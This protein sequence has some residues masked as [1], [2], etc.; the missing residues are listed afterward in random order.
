[1][2]TTE[3]VGSRYAAYSTRTIRLIGL[4][5]V[6]SG[7]TGLIYEVLWARM[8]GL[9]FGATT[10]AVSTVLAAFMGG[11]SLGS[12]LAGRFPVVKRPLR[13][14]GLLE[15]G[16]AAYA[17]LVPSLFHHVDDLYAYIWQHL[18]P[19]YF[20]FSIWRFALSCAIL[21]VPTTL[22]GATLP[23]LTAAVLRSSNYTANSVTRLYAYNLTGA[24]FGTLVAGFFLLPGIGL[25]STIY[26]SALINLA[27]GVVAIVLDRSPERVADWPGEAANANEGLSQQIESK[28]FWLFCAFISGFVTISIQVAWTRLLSMIIGSSTYAFSLVVAL[29][30]IGLSLGAYVVGNRNRSEKLRQ[31]VFRVEVATAVSL[32]LSL[33][34]VGALPDLLVRFGLLLRLNSW[35]GLLALQVVAASLLILLP[36]FLM[37]T[38]M[39]LV[40]VWAGKHQDSVGLVGHSYATNTIGAI[41]GAFVT[42]F[43]L[44]PKATTRFTI[45][46]AAALCIVVAGL[47]Y[48]PG[49]RVKDPSLQKALV[50]AGSFAMVIIFCLVAP[51]LNFPRMNLDALSIGAYDSLVR[52]LANTR[53]LNDSDRQSAPGEHRLLMYEEGTTSTVTVRKDW[54]SVSMAINGRTNG[55]DVGDMPTQV[56]LGQL[57]VLLAPTPRVGLVVG[58]ATGVTTGAMLQ[59][60]IESLECVELESATIK[61]SRYFEHVNNHPLQDPRLKLIIDD[62]RTYLRVTPTRYDMIVSEPSHPWVPGVANLFTEE[63]FELGRD[64]LTESGVFVQWLQIYQLSTN[65]LRSA[66]AT[67]SAVFP[68]VL[69]FRVGGVA[70]GKDLLLVGSK[71]PLTLN[72]V[73]ERVRD[74]RISTELARVQMNSEENI[75]SWFICDETRLR[76]AVDGAVI[77]TDDNM[78]IEVTVPREAFQPL[79]QANGAWVEMLR[80][81]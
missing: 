28:K 30:L 58:F 7:A 11:L 52:V 23:V 69:V 74:A 72:P 13:F 24:I 34:V 66:L 14:Y 50:F 46:F 53:D 76:P 4:C 71:Q 21:L 62:A 1:M 47:A 44:I 70:K 40:L 6:F 56:M 60:P 59:S 20:G 18:H 26:V 35:M 61:G 55:S 38:V 27:I 42:G 36:A 78:H 16:I 9:V 75:R 67:Y 33:I 10:L 54:E 45:L 79:M 2:S 12:A 41:A 48:T 65:S 19:G 3:T 81:Q 22:M 8:L 77:N 29:F 64:R 73:A 25:R 63:F 39:P 49:N 31:T 17:I 43:I 15:I 37:G 32:F 68:H 5:F 57:P 51:A 80:R